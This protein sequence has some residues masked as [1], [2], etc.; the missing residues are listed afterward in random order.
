M[1]ILTTA[2]C[3]GFYKQAV[4]KKDETFNVHLV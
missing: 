1:Y 2:T 3:Y 4:C